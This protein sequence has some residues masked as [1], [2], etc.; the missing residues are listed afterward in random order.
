M[1]SSHQYREFADECRRLLAL[2]KTQHQ[3]QVLEEMAEAWEALAKA[4]EQE[5]KPGH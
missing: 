3:R 4:A 1:R 2:A 5:S